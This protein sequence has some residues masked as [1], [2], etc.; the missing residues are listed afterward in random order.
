MSE[1]KVRPA[2]GPTYDA[3]LTACTVCGGA[4][5]R[6]FDRD[7]YRG[8]RIDR[9]AACGVLLV[10]PQYTDAWLARFYADY[11]S[12]ASLAPGDDVP[13]RKQIAVRT[14]GKRRALQWLARFQPPG[15]VLMVGC[16]DGLELQV[17]KELGWRPEGY[18]VDPATTERI[19][20]HHGVPVHCGDLATLA[21][22]VAPFDAVFMDQ[23]L[24]HPKNPGAYLRMARDLLRP[25]GVLFVASPNVRSLSACTKTLTGRLGLRG[26][27]RGRHY[28]SGHHLTGFSPAVLRRV[29]P[30]FGFAVLA[31]RAAIKPQRNPLTGLLGDH[32]PFLD[33]NFAVLARKL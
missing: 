16:G 5:L 20:A 29:L 10:N 9:C 7:D 14:E 32:L 11:N 8:N 18:D 28:D 17:G 30:Q 22:R 27:R 25:G 12:L 31:V 23:V 21:E 6:P 1:A 33:S 4:P 24:E 19:A 15:R 26:R 13:H 2:D 3:P